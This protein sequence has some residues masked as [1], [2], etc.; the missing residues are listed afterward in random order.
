MNNYI[1]DTVDRYDARIRLTCTKMEIRLYDEELT[2]TTSVVEEVNTSQFLNDQEASDGEKV[3]KPQAK[4]GT[5]LSKNLTRSRDKLIW[6][7]LANVSDLHT[8]I[9]LTFE[10]NETDISK[11]NRK[12]NNWASMVRRVKPDFMYIC[13]PEFQK[14]GAVHYHLLS[15]LEVGK[16][17]PDH[18]RRLFN[19]STKTWDVFYDIV[20]Y[21]S[22]GFAHCRNIHEYDENFQPALYMVKYMYKEMD[23]RLYQRKKVMCSQNIKKPSELT[24]NK[25]MALI[26]GNWL[27]ENG[28]EPLTYK[29]TPSITSYAVGFTQE[30]FS[31]KQE[32][33]NTIEKKMSEMF[34]ESAGIE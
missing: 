31:F 2:R 15:N 30:T 20:P 34:L 5:M 11:A 17:I 8:F 14:R 19:Q 33:Y 29:H 28:Y 13:V 16:D 1:S 12:F 21:W 6:Y 32:D 18:K 9:T 3:H 22:K 25:Q 27:K 7:T 24:V 26:I 23:N 10:A 4:E